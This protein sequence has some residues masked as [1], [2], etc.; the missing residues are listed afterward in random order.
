[1]Q[2]IHLINLL[3]IL[4]CSNSC[5]TKHDNYLNKGLY[6]LKNKVVVNKNFIDSFTLKTFGIIKL[7]EKED[8]YNLVFLL[9]EDIIKNM[10][11]NY[12]VT[13]RVV[14]TEKEIKKNKIT[15]PEL[16]WDFKPELIEKNGHKYMIHKV[17]TKLKQIKEFRFALY[18]R[19]GY[20]GKVLS[21]VISVKNIMLY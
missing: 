16:F 20:Q 5:V 10:V 19:E 15:K 11:E 6:E 12:S 17:T 3:L 7:E 8:T 21:K 4:L 1:M 18:H 9:N 14:P 2:K 13:I